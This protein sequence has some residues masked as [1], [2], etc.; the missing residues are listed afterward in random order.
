MQRNQM[1]KLNLPAFDIRLQEVDGQTKIFDVLRR[2]YVSL[3]PEEWVRQH[4]VHYL[5]N[6]KHYPTTLLAN[7]VPLRIG[8]KQIRR[9]VCCM[10]RAFTEE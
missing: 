8:E 9:T 5:I 4:F 10:T 3:T 2:R 6:Y 7:E 1:C